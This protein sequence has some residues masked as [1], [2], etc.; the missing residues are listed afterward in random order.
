MRKAARFI[1]LT[2]SW[3]E[4]VLSIVPEAN[5]CTIPNACSDSVRSGIARSI[6][7]TGKSVLFV[8]RLEKEKGFADL[9]LAVAQIRKRVPGIRLVCGGTGNESEVK[10][11][12]ETTGVGDL[13]EL[14]GWISGTIKQECFEHAALL[15]LPSYIENL[16]MVIIEAMAA[17]LPVVASAVGGIPDVIEAGKEGLLV[18]PGDV[19]ELADAIACLLQNQSIRTSMALNARQKYESHYSPQCV[20]PRVELIYQELGLTRFGNHKKNRI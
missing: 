9:L 20:I 18:E 16:P 14:R 3:K 10:S 8:G 13:V 15:A 19:G 11:W 7:Q 5:V 12:I 1:V 2:G 6:D 17:G 4:W